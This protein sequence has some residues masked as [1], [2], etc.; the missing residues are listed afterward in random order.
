MVQFDSGV[1]ITVEPNKLQV[2]DAGDRCDPEGGPVAAIAAKYLR[3]LPHVPYTGIGINF[4]SVASAADPT[5]QISERFL[6]PGPWHNER[7]PLRAVG[8]RFVYQI[9]DAR[10]TIGLEP[11]MYQRIRD[12][13]VSDPIAV[14]SASANFHRELDT[15]RATEHAV[16]IIEATPRDWNRFN[17]I[18][19]EILS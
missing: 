19:Q 16:S 2:R 13:K 12:G 17:Q 7:R 11:A 18:L 6:K 9:D 5:S 8:L 15:G 14:I 4:S 3:V 10:L 1:S